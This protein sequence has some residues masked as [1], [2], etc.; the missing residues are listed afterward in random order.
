MPS[1]RSTLGT[2]SLV[3]S[4]VVLSLHGCNFTENES[5]STTT[6]P[7]TATAGTVSMAYPDSFYMLDHPGAPERTEG[8]SLHDYG[9]YESELT[10]IQQKDAPVDFGLIQLSNPEGISFGEVR[11]EFAAGPENIQ[12]SREE[13]PEYGEAIKDTEFLEPIETV[14][15]GHPA[16]FLTTKLN[17]MYVVQCYLAVD[18]IIVANVYSDIPESAYLENPELYDSMFRSI[19]LD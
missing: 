3:A 1:K 18:G 14:I 19:R 15:D 11:D 8:Q 9:M 4:C 7:H 5:A 2:L 13:K 17:G 12:S 10:V 6:L 16:L